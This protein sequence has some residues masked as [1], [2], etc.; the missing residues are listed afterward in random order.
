MSSS[1]YDES[2]RR[3]LAHEGGYTN[4]AADPGGPTNWGITIWDAR[5]FWKA[6]A[7]AA[8]VR[9]MPLSVAKDIYK[10]KY[11]DA[12]H[13]DDL[14]AGID[15]SVF[16]YGVNS[17][18]GRAPKVLQ[19]CLHVTPDGIIGPNTI[20]AA[21]ASDPKAVINCIN[22]QRLNFLQHLGTWPVFGRGWGR[23][24]AEVR[25]VSLRMAAAPPPPPPEEPAPGKAIDVAADKSWFDTL[26]DFWKTKIL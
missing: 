4:D 2:L 7:T 17:G 15:Y 16:D 3:V 24:V 9:A 11:W 12:M 10:S 13:C 5:K 21:K 26:E 22:D 19:N 1:S 23:R 20:A 18:I 25:A 14:P 8:D 6:D